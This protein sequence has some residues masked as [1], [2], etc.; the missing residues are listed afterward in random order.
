MAD[1]HRPL[2]CCSY[3]YAEMNK[4]T[5]LHRSAF[6]VHERGGRRKTHECTS[7]GIAADLEFTCWRRKGLVSSHVLPLPS[8]QPRF[9]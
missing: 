3:F 6:I 9:N 8:L 2:G 7:G 1:D 5:H 4:L